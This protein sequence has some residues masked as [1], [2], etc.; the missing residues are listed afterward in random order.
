MYLH[1]RLDYL[2][3]T[4]LH[5]SLVVIFRICVFVFLFV[6]LHLYL[7]DSICIC[8][9]ASQFGQFDLCHVAAITPL[10]NVAIWF[11][12][13]LYYVM[14]WLLIL[15]WY[16]CITGLAICS[17]PGCNQWWWPFNESVYQSA[18]SV[19]SSYFH[20]DI[21]FMNCANYIL[22]ILSNL[23]VP[24]TSLSSR[25]VL[26]VVALAWAEKDCQSFRLFKN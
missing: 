8:V 10:K 19:C 5:Q 20:R 24:N 17:A 15:Y 13:T 23:L 26:S 6:F 9:F 7:S 14:W 11:V 21:N 16:W 4:R 3:C 22:Q 18:H 2:L 25:T 1:H 12:A